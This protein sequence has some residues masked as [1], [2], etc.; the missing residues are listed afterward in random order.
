[1]AKDYYDVLGVKRDATEKD[2]KKAF[3]RLAKQYHPD[4]NPDN[5]NAEA[6]FKEI[7]EAYEVLSDPQKRSNYDR[8]GPN[9]QQFQNAGQAWGGRVNTAD[10]DE[11]AYADIFDSI[12]N[13]FGRGRGG[14][15]TRRTRVDPFD[16]GAM[17]RDGENVE[18]PIAITLRE[19][20][21][22]G[23]RILT[24]AGTLSGE[25]RVTVNIPKGA[26]DGTKIRLTGK[27]QPGA[28]GG[29]AGDLYLVV[30]VELD[31]QFE[32][33]GDDLYIDVKVD[34]FTAMLG[35]EVE[36]PTMTRPIKAKI[37]PGTQSGRKLRFTGKGMPL[38]RKTD[39]YGD[40]YARILITVPANLTPLQRELVEQLRAS[41]NE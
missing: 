26:T 40:L 2:I 30:Q 35:G 28:N 14:T 24:M 10:F 20:Y 39:Q 36:V 37:T 21:E 22:G 6:K 31:R 33:K 29:Q 11:T 18:K 34:C 7:N 1:M 41:F 19:A 13:N 9:F 15:S 8:F 3:R 4:T 25:S 16:F 38:L 5:P 27:G 32:R 17:P 23:T 12:F